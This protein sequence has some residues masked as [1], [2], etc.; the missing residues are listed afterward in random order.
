MSIPI[1]ADARP[2]RAEARR[3]RAGWRTAQSLKGAA[4]SLPFVLGFIAL[5]IIPVGYAVDQSLYAIRSSGL[6]LGGQTSVFVGFANFSRGLTD[7]DFWLSVLRVAV[8]AAVQVP[9][10]LGLSLLVALLLDAVKAKTARIFRIGLLVPYMIPGVVATLIWIY[11]Y[12]PDV[13]PL[14]PLAQF[15]GWNLNLFSAGAM[16]PSIGNLLTWHGL[17]FNMLIIYA[18]LQG[19]DP[20]LLDA[21]R[22]DGASELR[23]ARSI[24]VPMVRGALVLTG[25]LSMIGLLQLFAEPL[26]FRSFVPQVITSDYTPTLAIYFQAFS[27]D[28]YNYAAALSLILASVIAVLS[29]LYY[30]FTNRPQP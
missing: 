30:K 24:K 18:S 13:G 9:V 28:N 16:W 14:T 3:R 22:V 23:V 19:L 12:S 25:M 5:F 1:A 4:F 15:F 26:L 17:G 21:A 11:L 8:F 7:S 10:M 6:G 29:F 20:E 27:S 2:R